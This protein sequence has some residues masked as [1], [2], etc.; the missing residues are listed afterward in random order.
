MTACFYPSEDKQAITE[1]PRTRRS[2]SACPR[3]DEAYAQVTFHV[4]AFSG[5]AFPMLH[6]VVVNV[7]VSSAAGMAAVWDCKVGH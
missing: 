1:Q 3:E 4:L 7:P 6:G 2:H 5:A